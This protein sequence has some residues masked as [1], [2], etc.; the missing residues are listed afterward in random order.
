M[1]TKVEA[2]KEIRDR[3]TYFCARLDGTYGPP[4][5]KEVIG[6]IDD[7]LIK[8]HRKESAIVANNIAAHN[9]QNR[10]KM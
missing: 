2:L 10:P 8:P 6:I 7:V 4:W 9:R 3:L 1:R 5:V